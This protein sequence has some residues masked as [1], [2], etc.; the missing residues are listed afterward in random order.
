M[1]PRATPDDFDDSADHQP[2]VSFILPQFVSAMGFSCAR[3]WTEDKIGFT[4]GCPRCLRK[5][6]LVLVYDH[7]HWNE[8][9]DCREQWGRLIVSARTASLVPHLVVPGYEPGA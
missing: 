5:A 3:E 9:G 7:Q 1:R 8:A 6:G 2:S 4:C